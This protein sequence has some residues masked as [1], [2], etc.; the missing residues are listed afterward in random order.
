MGQRDGAALRRR[1]VRRGDRRL[2]RAQLRRPRP[3]ACARWRASCAP[4]ASVVVLEIT[5][6][7]RPPLSTFYRVWFDRVV[8]V[9][10]RLAGDP[11]AYNYLPNSVKRFPGPRDLAA[12]MDRCGMDVRYVLTAGGIIALHVGTQARMTSPAESVEAIVG[13]A[14]EHVPRAARARSRSASRSSRAGTARSSPSTPARRSPPAASDCARCSCCWPPAARPRDDARARRVRGRRR[15]R[16]LRD[17]RPRRRPRRGGAAARRADRVGAGRPGARRRDR[18]PALLARVR[19][20][21]GR[22]H[23]RVRAR[24]V[25]CDVR[26]RRG[27]AAAASGR[28]GRDGRRRALPLPLRAEDRAPVRGVVR[29]RRACRPAATTTQVAGAR[30][31]RAAHRAGLPAARRHARRVGRGVEHRQAPRHRPARRDGDAAADPRAQARRGARGDGPA[32]D[33]Q[34]A[35]RRPSCASGSRPRGRSPTRR[36][37]RSRSSPRRRRAWRRWRS[38]LASAARWTS[39]PTRSSIATRR[40]RGGRLQA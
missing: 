35:S 14:G 37:R 5:T 24:A 27:R 34:P 21:R 38:G 18:R 28:L 20:A 30:R 12:R 9:I 8:P 1:R 29:A 32:R 15:A 36:R 39:S 33:P 3:R 10:G 22:R 25:A 13:I 23:A 26:A 7:T 19:R 16:A 17:A 40:T 4:A 6:P 2:R 11:E 31:L